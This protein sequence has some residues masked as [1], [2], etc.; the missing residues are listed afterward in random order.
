MKQLTGLLDFNTLFS[1]LEME[2]IDM[3]GIRM[4][5]GFISTDKRSQRVKFK[6]GQRGGDYFSRKPEVV[7]GLTGFLT[8]EEGGYDIIRVEILDIDEEGFTLNLSKSCA[9]ADVHYL[10][11]QYED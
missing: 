5:T 4:T 7:A 10:A 6:E 8:S 11:I 1:Y 3:P 2:N 9:S